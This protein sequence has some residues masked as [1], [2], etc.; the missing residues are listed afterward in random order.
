MGQQV[1]LHVRDGRRDWGAEQEALIRRRMWIDPRNAEM[2]FSNF[3]EE[4]FDA[5]AS[6]LEPNTRTKYRSHIDRQLLPEWGDWP[7]IGIFNPR[8]PATAFG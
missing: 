3:V 8:I 1:R 5:I 4:W 2:P 6:R 7:M